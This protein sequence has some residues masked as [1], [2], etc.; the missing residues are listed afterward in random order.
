MKW[1]EQ[2]ILII[3]FDFIHHENMLRSW[4]PTYVP[5]ELNHLPQ[6]E[7]GYM[8]DPNGDPYYALLMRLLIISFSRKITV[9]KNNV[10]FVA[11]LQ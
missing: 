5:W 11:Q 10:A 2:Y 4:K 9:F 3:C 6:L 8:L 7:L 1:F